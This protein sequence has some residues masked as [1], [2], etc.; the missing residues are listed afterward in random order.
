M[1]DVLVLEFTGGTAEQYRQV[2]EALGLDQQTGE[3]DW[4]AGLLHHAGA[5][6]AG[7]DLMVVEIWDSQAAQAAFMADRLGPALGQVGVP[8]PSRAEWLTLLGSH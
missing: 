3:G 5:A 2:N 6:T 4:P 1:A 8:A 7:G